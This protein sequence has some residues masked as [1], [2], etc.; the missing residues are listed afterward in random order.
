MTMSGAARLAALMY[1]YVSDIAPRA[2]EGTV[3]CAKPG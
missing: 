1:W 2:S 3:S